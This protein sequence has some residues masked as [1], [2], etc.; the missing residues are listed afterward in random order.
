MSETN[1]FDELLDEGLADVD[2]DLLG[3]DDTLP[4]VTLDGDTEAATPEAAGRSDTPP[5]STDTNAPP[6]DDKGRFS[7]KATPETAANPAPATPIATTAQPTT[8]AANP[9][10]ATPAWAP[11]TVTVDGRPFAVDGVQ[12]TKANGYTMLAAPEAQFGR[13]EQLLARGRQ[14][15]VREQQMIQRERAL[16]EKENAPRQPHPDEI[17]AKTVLELMGKLQAGDPELTELAGNPTLFWKH[18]YVEA[19]SAVMDA[20]SK[21]KEAE[22][23]KVTGEQQERQTLSTLAD[24][25]EA[26]FLAK[27]AD[28]PN[29]SVDDV[30]E[31][32]N[33]DLWPIR[34]SLMQM[35]NG[36][37][38]LF[39]KLKARSDLNTARVDRERGE[40][41]RKADADAAKFN[42][43]QQPKP[44]PQP[45]PR[46]ASPA[47]TD[48]RTKPKPSAWDDTFRTWNKRSDLALD[49]EE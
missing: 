3:S 25:T 39:A 40:K 29:L 49:D 44:Q 47:A 19:R 35:E 7:P 23:A 36:R 32:F 12:V 18:L 38:Y 8:E 48:Q 9:T 24:E 20:G 21:A 27:Q 13:V 16:L 2:P 15:E 22:Q 31:V 6:R 41:Q 11:H 1:V 28:L 4:D 43:T 33:H 26:I 45:A 42:A 14:Y 17:T 5:A 37:E 30:R 34:G 46:A 10:P